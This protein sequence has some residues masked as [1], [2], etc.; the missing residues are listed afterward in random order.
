[1]KTKRKGKSARVSLRGGHRP[2]KQ[3]QLKRTTAFLKNAGVNFA[4][5]ITDIALDKK[6]RRPIL[7]LYLLIVLSLLLS[8]LIFASSQTSITKSTSA[9]WDL[10]TNAGVTT[11]G[12]EI[13][14]TGRST[15]WYNSSAP[16]FYDSAYSYRRKITFDNSA[17]AENLANFPVMLK[18][19]N[20]AL[21]WSGKIQADLDDVIFKDADGTALKWEWETKAPTGESIAWV[22]IPQV[23]A[24]T[25]TDFIYMDY[26]NPSATDQSDAVNVWTNGFSDRYGSS[27]ASGNL[28]SSVSGGRALTPA[29]TPLYSQTGKIGNSIGVDG[30]GD[31]FHSTI[32][33]PV[34]QAGADSVWVKFPNVPDP[35]AG[36]KLLLAPQNDYRVV[37][38]YSDGGD[39]VMLRYDLF[40]STGWQGGTP[41]WQNKS[42]IFDGQWHQLA[43]T[44]SVADNFWGLYRDGVLIASGGITG[45][46]EISTTAY[47]PRSMPDST[48]LDEGRVSSVRRSANWIA[49]EYKNQGLNTY[50]TVGAEGTLDGFGYRRT[51]TFDNSAQAENLTNFPVMVK[52]TNDELNWSSLVQADLDD[53]IFVDSDNTTL[54]S[55]EWEKKLSSGES[56]AWVKVPQVDASSSTD[57]IYIYY[58]SATAGDQS[59]VNSAWDSNYKGVWHL[60]EA[61]G[62]LYD[63]TSNKNN[64]TNT[65]A[66]YGATGKI[67]G[68]MNFSAASI[69]RIN[70]GS[71]SSLNITSNISLSAWLTYSDTSANRVIFNRT[72][73]PWNGYEFYINTSKQIVLYSNGTHAASSAVS[74]LDNGSLHNVTVTN[75]G[76]TTR[77]YFDGAEVSNTGQGSPVSDSYPAYIGGRNDVFSWN[78][79]LDEVRA[80]GNVRSAPWIAAEYKNQGS[81]TFTTFG[82]P[83]NSDNYSYRRKITF[84]NSAQA[85]NLVGFP[86]VVKANNS[87]LAW[88]GL[89]Q[90]DMDDVVFVDADDSTPLS[91]EWESR[92]PA[93]NSIAWVKVPQINLSSSADYIYMYYGNGLGVNLEHQEG[94]WSNGYAGVWHLNEASGTI[95][96]ATKNNNDGTQSGGVTYGATGKVNSALDF[97][98]DNDYV[99]FGSGSSLDFTSNMTLQLWVK[100]DTTTNFAAISRTQAPWNSYAFTVQADANQRFSFYSAGAWKS[101]SSTTLTTGTWYLATVTF[102]GTNLRFYK[103]GALIGSPVAS[104]APVSGSDPFTIAQHGGGNYFDGIMDEVKA[105]STVRSAPWIAA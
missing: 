42:V 28:A 12:D 10:G 19:N 41:G 88:S 51:I 6:K 24:S 79:V 54:L 33:Y 48:F 57:K 101:S 30:S 64:G 37:D 80:S 26:G 8:P 59:V 66:T 87:S 21:A 103:D 89:I 94:V 29:G 15:S 73:A 81:N 98:G 50:T 84:D 17:Q 38:V 97:A 25:T 60:N 102:D 34:A 14:L 71:G 39:W 62:T 100:F 70:V 18:L 56:I 55:W 65:N 78:G 22:K 27:E 76:T 43:G 92:T 47:F 104:G 90:A 20:A 68:A 105:S 67:D 46:F 75:N 83:Q 77:Y 96:D 3:S 13:K 16:T 7:I 72:N 49:A 2:T 4:S 95:Y 53:V 85:E 35:V 58:G 9:D 11:T 63:A 36:Y 23:D 82:A 31:D 32:I 44:F 45:T 40:T 5:S 74:S 86:V 69:P 91:F 99:S 52:A 93:G 61:S 1:M